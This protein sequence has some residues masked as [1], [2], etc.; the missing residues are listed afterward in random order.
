MKALFLSLLWLSTPAFA[1]GIKG[2]L[3]SDKACRSGK[4]MVWLSKNEAEFKKKELLL[5]TLVPE[6]GTFEFYVLPGEYLLVA[7]NELG[8]EVEKVVSIVDKDA[9]LEISLS[10]KKK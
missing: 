7:S 9:L 10:E 8:C 3:S 5:H 6:R 1:L 4:A 2:R